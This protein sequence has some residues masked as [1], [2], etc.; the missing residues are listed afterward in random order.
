MAS[1]SAHAAAITQP[2]RRAS[3]PRRAAPECWRERTIAATPSGASHSVGANQA[4]P[5]PDDSSSPYTPTNSGVVNAD[6]EACA[7]YPV[8]NALP[9]RM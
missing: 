8:S 1:A 5:F 4:M 7:P 9:N 6:T 3:S 2:A